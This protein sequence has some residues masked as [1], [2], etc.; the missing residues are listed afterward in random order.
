MLKLASHGSD[1]IPC[2]RSGYESPCSQPG[3]GLK[4][5]VKINFDAIL[6]WFLPVQL[7]RI[8]TL[9]FVWSENLTV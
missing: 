6:Y 2:I 7:N 8:H 4:R 3:I 5:S 1:K 9:C